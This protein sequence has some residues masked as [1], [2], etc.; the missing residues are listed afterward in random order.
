MPGLLTVYARKETTK[1]SF[2]LVNEMDKYDIVIYKDRRCKTFY[3]RFMWYQ[4]SRPKWNSKTVVINCYRWKLI[5][6]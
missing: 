3:A 2:A 5:W 1:D 6:L 4:K